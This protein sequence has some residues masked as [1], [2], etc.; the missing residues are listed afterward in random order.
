MSPKTLLTPQSFTRRFKTYNSL[1][2]TCW[3][4][5][6]NSQLIH[7]K[8]DFTLHI[9]YKLYRHTQDM[10]VCLLQQHTLKTCRSV[11]FN[12]THSRHAGLSPS[13]T[14]TQDMQVC[15]LQQPSPDMGGT[16]KTCRSVSFNNR[17]QTWKAPPTTPGVTI[18][19]SRAR[20]NNCRASASLSTSHSGLLLVS[21]DHTRCFTIHLIMRS[22]ISLH[23]YQITQ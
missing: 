12:N 2:H 3:Q 22:V 20:H 16:L 7:L 18:G 13:T 11:S 17:A 4:L 10:Q 23:I 15:L 9:N 6:I 5:P 19:N 14:H 21:T 8:Y 1:Q